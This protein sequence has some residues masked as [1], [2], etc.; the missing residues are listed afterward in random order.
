MTGAAISPRETTTAHKLPASPDTVHW[1]F[2]DPELPAVLEVYPGDTVEV[3]TVS[4]GLG[5]LPH[6]EPGF[7]ILTD[8]E[9]IVRACRPQLGPHVLTGPIDIAGTKTGDLL[10]VTFEAVWLRQDWAWNEIA[11][12]SGVLSELETD[13]ELVTIPLDPATGTVM[14]PWARRSIA[15]KPFFGVVAVR[16]PSDHG[17]ITSL[18]PGVFGGNIDIRLL[19]AGTT[20]HMP[21]HRSGGGLSVGDGHA[22]QGDGEANGTAAETSLGARLRV[23]VTPGGAF[24][25]FP[26]ADLPG[27]VLTLAVDEDLERAAKGALAQAVTLLERRFG[28]SRKAA[29]RHASLC[30]NLAVSQLV[31]VRKGI[32]CLVDVANLT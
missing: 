15:A 30:G 12:A 24:L 4:G 8:H 28:L 11:P 31:N 25:P 14:P 27:A 1:G 17:R 9:A 26:H 20:L 22:L 16:P 7:H 3:E 29:Y 13:I 18:V 21:V 5:R 23:G 2:L 19:G 10:S 32:H 6:D